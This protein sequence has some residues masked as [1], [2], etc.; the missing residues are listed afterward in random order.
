MIF[1]AGGRLRVNLRRSLSPQERPV[2][3]ARADTQSCPA[4]CQKETFAHA[5]QNRFYGHAFGN[6]LVSLTE[7]RRLLTACCLIRPL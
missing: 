4:K 5:S 6:V 1:A 3:L 2:F 7:A